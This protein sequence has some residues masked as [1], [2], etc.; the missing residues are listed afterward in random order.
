MRTEIFNASECRTQCVAG[1]GSQFSNPEAS[2]GMKVT[3]HR[4]SPPQR[5]LKGGTIA[6]FGGAGISRTIRNLSET[7][8]CLE[9]ASPVDIPTCFMLVI[10]ANHSSR[11]CKI[12][13]KGNG[14]GIA[15]V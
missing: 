8:A 14:I 12:V 4:I 13:W 1:I 11:S 2:H 7:G 3:E 6:A 5:V 9:V 15:C 10:D